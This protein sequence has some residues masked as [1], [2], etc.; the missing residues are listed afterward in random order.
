MRP[1]RKESEAQALA[2]GKLNGAGSAEGCSQEGF[3]RHSN[4]DLCREDVWSNYY[5]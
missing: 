5:Y 4:N 2:R 3:Q 1:A